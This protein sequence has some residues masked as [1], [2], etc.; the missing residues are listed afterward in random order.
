VLTAVSHELFE[1]VTDPLSHT[2]AYAY[3]PIAEWWDG[4][5]RQLFLMVDASGHLL[6]R[7][8][9]TGAPSSSRI[10]SAVAGA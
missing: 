6:V 2:T 3:N 4:G 10:A 9:D 1:T 7:R 5:T 8:G